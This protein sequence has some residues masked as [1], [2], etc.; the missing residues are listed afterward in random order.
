M[1]HSDC[2]LIPRKRIQNRP[3]FSRMPPIVAI[4]KTYYLSLAQRNA[5]IEC[6]GLATIRLIKICH[7]VAQALDYLPCPIRRTIV[8]KYYL[9][10]HPPDVFLR[11]DATYCGPDILFVIVGI[12][13]GR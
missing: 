12:Y 2:S 13:Q 4:E 9:Y 3:Y 8:D 1:A 6:G 10:R 11:Q 5:E 7:P